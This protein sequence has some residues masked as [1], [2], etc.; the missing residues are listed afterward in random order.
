ME[1]GI[2]GTPPNFDWVD[3]FSIPPAAVSQLGQ[4]HSPHIACLLE[5][6]LTA[7]S[8]YHLVSMPGC[9]CQGVNA[10][11]SM[12][13]CQCQGVNARVSMPGCQ[14]QGKGMN[15]PQRITVI[16]WCLF[17]QTP[18]QL[19]WEESSHVATNAIRMQTSITVY[20]QVLIHTA[21]WTGAV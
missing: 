15:P 7:I 21:E 13:G 8:H 20:S 17:N 10:R 3:G 6:T 9:Q 2:C 19:L 14:C 5:E 16:I 4:F 11:V 12:P 1:N 18:S